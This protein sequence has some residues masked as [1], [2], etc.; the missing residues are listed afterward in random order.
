MDSTAIN[1]VT[2][3]TDIYPMIY[4]EKLHKQFQKK[5]N[6]KVN[7]YC[8]TDRPKEL[9]N[10]VE[11][12][13]IFKKSI[14]W[15][16]KINLFSPDMPKGHILYLDIDIVILDNFDEEILFMKESKE[17][18]CCVSDA[19]EW[20]GIKFSS[21]LMF[22]KSGVH[23]KIFE[24][25]L[26]NESLINNREGGDQ[27]WIG[28]QLDS[29]CYVEERYPNLK[30]NFKFHLAEREGKKF[31]VPLAIDSK[32]KLIDFGGKT[33]PHQFDKLPY[34]KKNWHLV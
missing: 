17:L 12:I 18:I 33:K 21:S 32:I 34:I 29:I 15:W 14:G 20:M 10:F 2:V 7:H 8:I 4:V 5:T 30:K 3:C 27:V 16:N 24:N 9:P 23:S 1:L 28:P 26:K 22:F 19:I 11:P 25:F 31:T 13:H 6:L